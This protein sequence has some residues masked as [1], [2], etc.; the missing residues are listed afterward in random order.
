MHR[1]TKYVIVLHTY[2]YIY[3]HVLNKLLHLFH[4]S[5]LFSLSPKFYSTYEGP[6][7]TQLGLALGPLSPKPK[8]YSRILL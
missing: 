3:Y 1:Y 7:N 4:C 6:C 5:S 2:I 8:P